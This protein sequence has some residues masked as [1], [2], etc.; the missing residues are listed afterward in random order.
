M[1]G[2]NKTALVV[3]DGPDIVG[4]VKKILEG[5]GFEVTGASDGLEVFPRGDRES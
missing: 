5:E 4:I 3:D 1:A 2:T